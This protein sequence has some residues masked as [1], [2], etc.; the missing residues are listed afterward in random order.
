VPA[1]GS[2]KSR[3][4]AKIQDE[5]P[6]NHDYV[7]AADYKTGHRGRDDYEESDD[8][9][10]DL[11]LAP[12]RNTPRNRGKVVK[13]KVEE[14][15]SD[16]DFV[17]ID[18]DE[19]PPKATK[20]TKA[21]RS[22]KRKSDEFDDDDDDDDEPPKK[23]R[24]RPAKASKA[25]PTKKKAA[26]KKKDK[27][28]EPE[29]AEIKSI[30]DNIPLVDAPAPPEREQGAKWNMSMA[31]N[32]KAVPAAAGSKE[33]PV[34][35]ENCLAGLSF[36][37]TGV[38]ESLEREQ[39]QALVK[40]YGGKVVG[41]PSGKTSYVVLGADAGPSKLKKIRD[42]GL[43]TIN[44][45]GLYE[46]IRRLP[47]NGG[48][49]K[50]ANE[51]K[52]RAAKEAEKARDEAR[53]M[54][55]EERERR[56]AVEKQ[57]AALAN[58]KATSTTP[59]PAPKPAVQPS[60]QLWTVKYAP[61]SMSQI[62]G[63][64]APVEKLSR[65]LRMFPANL[66]K[67]FLHGGPDGS[68]THRAVMIHG[69]PGIGKTTAAHLVAKLEG[70]DVV[71]T[72]ASDTRSKKMVEEGLRG[73]LNTRSL[74]GY[75]AGD[76]KD[77]NESKRK[78]VLILDEVD[79]MSAG[80]RGGV[81]ALAA[82]CKKSSIPI[83]LICNERRLPKMKPFDN[84]V[85]ELPFRR[86]TTDQIRSRMM[87]IAFRE[88]MKMPPNVLNAL[89][90]GTGADIRQIVNMISASKLDETELDFSK[91]KDMSKAWE[92]HII[93]KPWDIAGKII[94]GGLFAPNSTSTL[95]DKIELYFNDHDFSFLML[96][97]NYLNTQP[98]LA[99]NYEGRE[100]ILKNIELA[101]EAADAI[102]DGDM[103]DRM[104]H[105]TQQHWSLMPAH[106]VMS[107]VRPASYI[108]GSS[109]FG[110][111]T[112]FTSWLGNNS[113]YGKLS[114]MVREMQGHM[115]LRSSADRHEV[116]QHYVPMLWNQT[117]RK[118]A[119]EGK[120]AVQ[121]VIDLL[122]SYFLTK[123]DFDAVLELGV[124]PMDE[125]QVKIESQTKATFTRM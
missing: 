103:V 72:N 56:K 38:L 66:K 105:G 57:R 62:V 37:F 106:A 93:L 22:K 109:A 49:G 59:A 97:E 21:S 80:D 1:N 91:S 114:R 70:Y 43:K 100:K 19:D 68:G 111:Q 122:D 73:V 50:A 79:G 125:G 78:L 88:K 2:S 45:D 104:I 116:R 41:A 54:E 20:S 3:S 32:N 29:N 30:L 77:V 102:S 90:E 11:I 87:T 101:S 120:E 75:F 9:D 83:I 96:Q 51:A 23:S 69:P 26:V 25:T 121:D 81:G 12:R 82:I 52:E 110:G 58:S 65:W 71:E 99:S 27:G 35:E 113:K 5:D 28:E 16:D 108:A 84:A 107:F 55:E 76:G 61:T 8:D 89:I 36:V 112:R 44:E 40:Q 46:L 94:G 15:A 33:I 18:D 117:A 34:G 98:M 10:E 124:G 67:R 7:F 119:V 115:R 53:K 64:K 123:D 86:P 39:G 95:N 42:H 92:K 85:F 6:D 47:A 63:N 17:V 48:S 74:L 31:K 118:L 24:G 13:Q 4:K 14:T 60:S